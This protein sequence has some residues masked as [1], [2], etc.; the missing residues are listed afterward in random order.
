MNPQNVNTAAPESSGRWGENLSVANA[1]LA[2][3]LIEQHRPG[4]KAGVTVTEAD[5]SRCGDIQVEISVNGDLHW[6][7]W[8]FEQE[9]MADLVHNL[10]DV[11]R[12]PDRVSKA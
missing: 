3:A 5:V 9:F 1:R 7:A 4:L 12:H 6:R 11:V 8:S 10:R 2:K